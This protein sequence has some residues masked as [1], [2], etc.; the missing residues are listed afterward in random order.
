MSKKQELLNKKAAP[1]EAAQYELDDA[2][3][4]EIASLMALIEQAEAARNFIYSQIVQR[5]ADRHGISGKEV[6]LNFEEI[7][8]QGAKVARLIVKD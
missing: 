7:M 3:R 5:A 1:E 4:L 6:G 2:E 8:E